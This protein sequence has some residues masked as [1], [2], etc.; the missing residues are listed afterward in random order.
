VAREIEEAIEE[1]DMRTASSLF[2]NLD[3]AW[4]QFLRNISKP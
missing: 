3:V 4:A 1:D 2:Q